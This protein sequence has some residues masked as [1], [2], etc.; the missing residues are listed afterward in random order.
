[1]KGAIYEEICPWKV[2]EPGVNATR[3]PGGTNRRR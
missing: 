1:M 2:K 3:K